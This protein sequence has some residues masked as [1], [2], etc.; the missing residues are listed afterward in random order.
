MIKKQAESKDE[1]NLDEQE[2]ETDQQEIERQCAADS[3]PPASRRRAATWIPGRRSRAAA[4]YHRELI[5][6][7]MSA[8]ER[9][10][11]ANQSGRGGDARK[12]E[13]QPHAPTLTHPAILLADTPPMRHERGRLNQPEPW[14]GRTDHVSDVARA[15]W[16]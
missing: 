9:T 8:L 12:S 16:A 10:E 5:A 1:S 6:A 15:R 4:A 14:H 7:S 11:Q 13:D 2:G 3:A